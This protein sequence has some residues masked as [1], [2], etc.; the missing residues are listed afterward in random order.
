MSAIDEVRKLAQSLADK[1]AASNETISKILWFPDTEII[2]LVIVDSESFPEDTGTVVP[3]YFS[4]TS[5]M[6][7]PC[8]IALILPVEDGHLQ[9][10]ADWD[11]N[12]GAAEVLYENQ[13][14]TA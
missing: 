13:P 11:T 14:A 12:W 3:Y 7:L 6:E 4:A 2:R 8:G 10:P 9:L 1:Q 5:E